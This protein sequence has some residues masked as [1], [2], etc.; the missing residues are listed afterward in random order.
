M[1]VVNRNDFPYPIPFNGKNIIIPCDN[2]PHEIPD[3]LYGNNFGGIIVVRPPLQKPVQLSVP[4]L[5]PNNQTSVQSPIPN[6]IINS[7]LEVKNTIVEIEIEKKEE[8]IKEE[9]KETLENKKPLSGKKIKKQNRD[10]NKKN[11][12]TR[13]NYSGEKDIQV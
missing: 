11:M 1:L 4:N 7:I 5:V 13:F 10:K 9:K 8:V 6:P 3:Q 2:I 12:D